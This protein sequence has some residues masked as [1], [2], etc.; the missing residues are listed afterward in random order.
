MVAAHSKVYTEGAPATKETVPNSKPG[1]TYQKRQSGE[2]ISI[3]KGT[4]QRHQ[5]LYK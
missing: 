5:S 2:N 1:H 4:F 3:Y